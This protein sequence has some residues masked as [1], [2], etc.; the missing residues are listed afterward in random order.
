MNGAKRGPSLNPGGIA[1]IALDEALLV[2]NKWADEDT[3]LRASFTICECEVSLDG[4]IHSFEDGKL[5]FRADP[6]G[7]IKIHLPDGTR[8]DYCHPD[9]MGV[10]EAER[11]GEG[12]MGERVRHGA[13]LG[14]VRETGERFFFVEIEKV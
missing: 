1:L 2:I 14:V 6:L 8:F 9:A 4:R 13:G 3:P 12:H 10:P 11:I 5:H 7:F